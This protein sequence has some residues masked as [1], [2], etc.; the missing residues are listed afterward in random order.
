M[1]K[2]SVVKY[3]NN[4]LADDCYNPAVVTALSYSKLMGLKENDSAMIKTLERLTKDVASGDLS[5]V[6]SMLVAQ[7]HLLNA[8]MLTTAEKLADAKY[9]QQYQIYGTIALK[10]Q[11]LSRK[12]AITINNIK[13]PSP[14]TFIKNT[15]Q[16]Q[17]VNFN[18]NSSNEL[19]SEADNETVDTAGTT[20]PGGVDTSVETMD[21]S[22][23]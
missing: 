1:A 8:I 5:Q 11:D 7:M 12:T 21:K 18:Q 15:A 4:N 13:H 23:S 19:L 22:R 2:N 17:Q 14:T 10:A 3:D 16:N 9:V 20:A 6:E